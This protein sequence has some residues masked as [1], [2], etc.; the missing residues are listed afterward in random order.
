MSKY[1]DSEDPLQHGLADL[2]KALFDKD[3]I[4]MNADFSEREIESLMKLKLVD[5]FFVKAYMSKEEYGNLLMQGD[6]S[7]IDILIR[8]YGAFKIGKNRKGRQELIEAL[9]ALFAS[10]KSM[11][12]K[13]KDGG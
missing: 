9:K 4:P 12:D 3:L 13:D 2:V 5:D 10:K 1:P 11:K 8:N 7:K 6:L